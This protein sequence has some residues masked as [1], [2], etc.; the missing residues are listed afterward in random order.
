MTAEVD[1]LSVTISI[2]SWTAFSDM[3]M[4]VCQVFSNQIPFVLC[5][6]VL[7]VNAVLK[8]NMSYKNPDKCK[9]LGFKV[10][11]RPLVIFFWRISD[12]DSITKPIENS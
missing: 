9:D 1:V 2:P 12:M 5:K 10:S 3:V 11:T 8:L 4:A 6:D 7:A